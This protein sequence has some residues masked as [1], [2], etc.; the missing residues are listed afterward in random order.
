MMAN[1]NKN[2]KSEDQERFEEADNAGRFAGNDEDARKAKE[3]ALKGDV[4]DT[5]GYD[6]RPVQND[7]GPRSNPGDEQTNATA[8]RGSAQVQDFT[9]DAQ[10]I[11]DEGGRPM[12][13]TELTHARNKANKS[14]GDENSQG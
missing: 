12:K 5:T 6:S 10:N 13:N 2:R 14:K 3:A 7:S 1:K 9:G 4:R 8:H 11:N